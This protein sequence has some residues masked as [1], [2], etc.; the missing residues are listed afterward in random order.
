M[1]HVAQLD[2]SLSRELG[3]L[4]QYLDREGNLVDYALTGTVPAAEKLKVLDS[5]VRFNPVDVVDGL[6]T[7]KFS[8]EVL[9]HNVA[10]LKN[11]LSHGLAVL[12]RNTQCDVVAA[13]PSGDL[14]Q[15][16]FR[17]MQFACPFVLALLTAQFLV[18]I[19][20]AATPSASPVEFFATVLAVSFV[21]LVGIFAATHG[22]ARHRA[23][24]WIVS[25]FLLVRTQVGGF[26]AKTAAAFFASE[27]DSVNFGRRPPVQSLACANAS[28][29]TEFSVSFSLARGAKSLLAM[30]ANLFSGHDCGSL[31]SGKQAVAHACSCV[32]RS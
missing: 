22:R 13:H 32:K 10:V 29:R 15:P 18:A 21:A 2:T 11:V 31:F 25:E 28:R 3:V 26:V 12:R 5:V 19:N 6:V 14:G 27:S 1:S 30:L 24:Q 23:V 8:S 7:K 16:V 4:S 17:A 9:L 20:S